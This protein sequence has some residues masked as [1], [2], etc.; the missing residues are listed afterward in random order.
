MAMC[1]PWAPNLLELFM[2]WERTEKEARLWQWDRMKTER[3]KNSFSPSSLSL[4]LF[5]P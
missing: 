2:S 5:P 3:G 4:V 1:I